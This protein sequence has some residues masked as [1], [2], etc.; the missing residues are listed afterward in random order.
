[1]TCY[2]GHGNDLSGS[3]MGLEFLYQLSDYKLLEDRVPKT[4]YSQLSNYSACMRNGA[5]KLD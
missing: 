4:M 1:M 3:I 5:C 2:C